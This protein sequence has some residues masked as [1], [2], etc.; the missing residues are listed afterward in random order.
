MS[1]RCIGCGA[2]LQSEHK[3]QLGYTPKPEADYCQR[4]FRIR[5]YDDVVISMKQGIDSDAVL[6]RVAL[7][8][9]LVLWVVDLFDFEANLLPGINRHLKGKDIVLVATKRDLLPE[10]VGN[11]KLAQFILRRLKQEGITLKGVVIC[12]DLVKN[13]QS[14]NNHSVEEVKHVLSLVRN[15]RSVTVVG[16]ANAGK[17]TLL[18]ALLGSSQLTTSRHPGTTLDFTELTLDGFTLIDT[19]G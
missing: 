15:N 8:D 18:N 10:T 4:C 14:E 16:M 9:T 1:K 5:H 13:A 6:S 7:M 11:E 19:P 17:S 2:L 3:D 12:G